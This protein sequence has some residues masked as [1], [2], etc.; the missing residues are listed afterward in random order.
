M[1]FFITPLVALVLFCGA[2]RVETVFS[3]RQY[4]RE[5][6]KLDSSDDLSLCPSLPE[7]SLSADQ[8]LAKLQDSLKQVDEQIKATLEED[9]S[10]GGAVV[11]VVY[12][13]GVIW[14]KG[15]GLKNMSGERD[16]W[17]VSLYLLQHCYLFQLMGLKVISYRN[18]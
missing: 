2:A 15:Y 4:S 14:S 1:L 7:A 18:H 8:L 3:S 9:K 12:G 13:D 16:D 5:L 17:M 11:T 10:P 6:W